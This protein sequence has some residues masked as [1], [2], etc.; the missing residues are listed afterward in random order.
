MSTARLRADLAK[1]EAAFKRW[2]AQR[3]APGEARRVVGPAVIEI[4][5]DEI[6]TVRRKARIGRSGV[7]NPSTNDA[8]R[9]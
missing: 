5:A 2:Q 9:R 8:Y 7:R 1:V 3:D 4:A 6:A